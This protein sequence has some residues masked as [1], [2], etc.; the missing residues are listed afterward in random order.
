MLAFDPESFPACR[1][2]MHTGGLLENALGQGGRM[3]AMDLGTGNRLW[4]QYIAG[5]A[6]PWLSGEWLFVVTDDARLLCIARG[7]GKIRWISQLPHYR[8]E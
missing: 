1:Q 2:D 5:I 8:N 7:T 4:E 3:V 6:T